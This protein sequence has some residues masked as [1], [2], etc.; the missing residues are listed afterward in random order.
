[1]LLQVKEEDPRRGVV[2]FAAE[3][4]S[5]PEHLKCILQTTEFLAF[6]RRRYE[7]DSMYQQLLKNGGFDRLPN[8]AAEDAGQ[9]LTR[10]RGGSY[11][12]GYIAGSAALAQQSPAAGAVTA[13]RA[14]E[15]HI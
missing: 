7:A 3:A 4:E 13:G 5:A 2:D 12:E 15:D 8:E 1:M 11:R 14:L 6:R 9:P 10:S